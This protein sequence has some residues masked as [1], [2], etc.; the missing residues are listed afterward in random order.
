[1]VTSCLVGLRSFSLFSGAMGLD[2]G[3]ELTGRFEVIASVEKEPVFAETIR[4]N[5]ISGRLNSRLRVYECDIN[6]LSPE[7]VLD[8][9]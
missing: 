7:E 2:L 4:R 8:D 5:L 3:L 6:D 9:S 1:M